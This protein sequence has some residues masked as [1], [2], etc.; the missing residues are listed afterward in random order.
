MEKTGI[1]TIGSLVFLLII[2]KGDAK[3][4][5]NISSTV[6]AGVTVNGSCIFSGA[7]K[8][9]YIHVSTMGQNCTIGG[10]TAVCTNINNFNITCLSS[11]VSFDLECY[12]YS[13]NK[14]KKT[15][16]QIKVVSKPTIIS[17]PVNATVTRP[18][19]PIT[20]SCEVDGDPNH[21]WVGWFHRNSMIQT[22][23]DDRS[24]SESP[25][26]RSQQ[27]TTHHLTVHSVKV[28]GKYQCQVFT[29]QDGN[30]T[31]QVTHR[32]SIG[33]GDND[34]SS[35]LLDVLSTFVF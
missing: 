21:Y 3:V 14:P 16:K 24:V 30:V 27:G 12:V 4:E 9:R 18:G 15:T 17:P 28:A 31:D 32:V 29:I 34:R 10:A 2:S 6:I 5:L 11:N 13:S 33:S 25:S 35:S 1:A 20:L 19:L 22:D 7:N 23:D 8:L 26:V